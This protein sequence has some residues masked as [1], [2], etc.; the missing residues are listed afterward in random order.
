MKTK[1]KTVMT[2]RLITL[3]AG[4]SLQEAQELMQEKRIRHLPILDTNA[5]ILGVL[6]DRDIAGIHDPA[7][8]R[9]EDIMKAHVDFVSQ[10][11]PLRSAILKMLEKHLS[12][13]LVCDEFQE[14]VG[15]IT[16]EDLLW[17]LAHTLEPESERSTLMG[18]LDWQT[19]NRAADQISNAG[20]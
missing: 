6:S 3:P 8:L 18:L 2:R 15:I 11:M 14:A 10:E 20:L 7:S 5:D 9:V 1:V 13:I 19:L 16:T 17:Y 4:S 12:A